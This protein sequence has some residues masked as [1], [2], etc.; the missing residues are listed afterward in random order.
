MNKNLIYMV[1][2][3]HHTSIYK[4][5]DYSKYSIKTWDYWCK[6]NNVDFIVNETHDER[7]GRPIWNKELIYKIGKDYDKIG[8]ID[9]D[10][11]IKWDTP[12]IF[13]EF[14][15]DEFCGVVD[16]IN[17]RWIY[18]SINVYKK[19]FPDT[20]IDLN[21]YFNAGVL[22]FGNKYL[23]VFKDV[24]NFYLDN[25]EELDNWKLGGGKE[26][27]ILNYHLVKHD[28]NKKELTP[29]WNLLGMHRRDLFSHNW[30]VKDEPSPFFI[31]YGNIWHFT[32][33][34]VEDRIQIMKQTWEHL[35]GNYE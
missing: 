29:N 33:F 30:Q 18:D 15:D 31:K 26:Q 8:V 23:S 5:T 11:M 24:L 2:I 14:N 32:G 13:D 20:D 7:F 25:Q 10:T 17:L 1:S 21:S 4:N 34:P 3:N 6:K 27:T 12:N 22:F 35:R 28:V 9:S 19:F 16:N